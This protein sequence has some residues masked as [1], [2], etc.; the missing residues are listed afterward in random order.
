M[1]IRQLEE[2]REARLK[3]REEM[4]RRA[5]QEAEWRREEVMERPDAQRFREIEEELAKIHR[6]LVRA[7]SKLFRRSGENPVE[8]VAQLRD[9]ARKLEEER[10]AE[11]VRLGY[12]PD[13]LEVKYQC[14]KCQDTG[15]LPPQNLEEGKRVIPGGKCECLIKEELEDLY[16]ISGLQGPMRSWTFAKFNPDLFPPNVRNKMIALKNECHTFAQDILDGKQVRPLVLMGEVGRGKTFLA[17]AIAN[18]LLQKGRTVAFLR[19]NELMRLARHRE[20]EQNDEEAKVLNKLLEADLLIVDDLGTAMRDTAEGPQVTTFTKNTIL[21]IL[22]NRVNGQKPF[23]IT[24]NLTPSQIEEHYGSRISS[25]VFG[26]CTIR[27][28]EGKD[29]RLAIRESQ[30]R[31][32]LHQLVSSFSFNEN[33]TFANLDPNL[34]RGDAGATM[35]AFAEE[36]RQW[37]ADALDE[38]TDILI[39]VISGPEGTGKTFLASCIANEF[40]EAHRDVAY[41]HAIDL[42]RLQREAKPFIEKIVEAPLF[43]LDD[44]GEE[45]QTEM[46]SKL[47]LSLLTKRFKTEKPVIITTTLTEREL[48]DRYGDW[49]ERMLDNDRTLFRETMGENIAELLYGRSEL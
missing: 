39:F 30:W 40:L 9:R 29:L 8:L 13:Y 43:L 7:A 20:F 41:L 38:R 1:K 2:M 44:L 26:F 31:G 14:P 34:Y 37:A 12:P 32:Q 23:V 17:T 18:T 27:S 3:R 16:A 49:M 15:F 35:R 45:K 11:L 22:E 10:R 24:T 48:I 33:W 47:L 46:N 19:E 28:V 36:C 6:Q 25:R 42:Q 4:R 21:D 5:Q